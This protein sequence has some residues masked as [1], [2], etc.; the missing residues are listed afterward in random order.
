VTDLAQDRDDIQA[1][2]APSRTPNVYAALENLGQEREA[3]WS[4]LGA[5]EAKAEPETSWSALG[6][7]PVGP[8]VTRW[9]REDDDIVPSGASGGKGRTLPRLQ[10]RRRAAA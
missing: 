4:A 9:R 8:E 5:D 6:A 7:E 1:L 10:L 2:M 3:E